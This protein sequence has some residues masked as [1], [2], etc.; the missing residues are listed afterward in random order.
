MS[1]PEQLKVGDVVALR[2]GGYAM[3][4][5][6]PE[7]DKSFLCDWIDDQGR[8]TRQSFYAK[9]LVPLRRLP[10]THA[11]GLA[12]YVWCFA[13]TG[14]PIAEHIAFEECAGMTPKEFTKLFE[15]AAKLVEEIATDTRHLLRMRLQITPNGVY[16][17]AYATARAE[18]GAGHEIHSLTKLVDFR[19]VLEVDGVLTDAVQRLANQLKPML[20]DFPETEKKAAAV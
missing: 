2:S 1:E 6:K 11:D 7:V 5:V 15:P 12:R 17:Q 9:S 16:I 14:N 4:I 3:T 19:D 20:T 18:V 13:D 10:I 8:H